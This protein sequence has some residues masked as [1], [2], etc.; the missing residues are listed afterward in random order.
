MIELAAGAIVVVCVLTLREPFD[1]QLLLLSDDSKVS[2]MS[3]NSLT[4]KTKGL[5]HPVYLRVHALIEILE[6]ANSKLN[7]HIHAREIKRP[8]V[9]GQK[10]HLASYGNIEFSI[11]RPLL[12]AAMHPP[13]VLELDLPSSEWTIQTDNNRNRFRYNQH[14]K[15]NWDGGAISVMHGPG[16]FVSF[17]VSHHERHQGL[18]YVDWFRHQ[19]GKGLG[20]FLFTGGWNVTMR[21]TN[22]VMHEPRRRWSESH[23][24]RLVNGDIGDALTFGPMQWI[25]LRNIHHHSSFVIDLVSPWDNTNK[26]QSFE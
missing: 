21:I 5:W 26:L 22:K 24:D 8:V 15:N 7:K 1:E 10:T 25:D 16:R 2:H 13:A 19:R 18:T 3:V 4:Q 23:S 12:R 11:S 20:A 9:L 14:R 6:A 17:H